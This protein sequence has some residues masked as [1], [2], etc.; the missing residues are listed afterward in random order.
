MG[1][2]NKGEIDAIGMKILREL[3]LNSRSSFTE[4]GNKVGLSSPAAAERIRK[5]E[6]EGVIKGYHADIAPEKIGY[7]IQSFILMTAL[8]KNDQSVYKFAGKTSEI[9]ECH[10]VSGSECFVLRVAV[11]SV[12]DLDELVEKLNTFGETKTLIVLSTPVA[13]KFVHI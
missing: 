11:S 13:K 1:L 8:S 5:M 4:I 6:K 10:R 12:P 7:P 3:Q 9:I 2:K